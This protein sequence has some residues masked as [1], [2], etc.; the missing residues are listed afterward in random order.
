MAK[1]DHDMTLVLVLPCPLIISIALIISIVTFL[2]ITHPQSYLPMLFRLRESINSYMYDERMLHF[3]SLSART[4]A[5]GSS[6]QSL[7]I[8]RQSQMMRYLRG[9]VGHNFLRMTSNKME[10]GTG[11]TKTLV[12]SQSTSGTSSCASASRQWVR[13][14]S[15]TVD[16]TTNRPWSQCWFFDHLSPG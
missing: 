8:S 12:C 2:P 15:N 10:I 9:R 7:P 6:C 16:T 3:L 4:L 5:R 14:A 13:F 11:S 1:S